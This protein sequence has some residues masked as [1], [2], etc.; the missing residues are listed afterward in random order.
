[1]K[2]KVMG[3]LIAVLFLSGCG[4][5]AAV[6]ENEVPVNKEE[7]MTIWAW[8]E[9]FNIPAANMAIERYRQTHEDARIEVVSM[10]QEE[11]V[12]RLKSAIVSGADNLLPD[13]VLIEDYRIQHF[14]KNYEEEFADLSE[15]VHQDDF[16]SYKMGVNQINGKIY[17][18]PFDSG[19]VGL[20]YRLDY[21]EAAGYRE[22]DMENLTWEEY[23]A[24]GKAVK[25]ATGKDM[26][27]LNPSDLPIIRMMLQ[28]AGKWYCDKNGEVF[29]ADNQA[30]EEA[31]GVYRDIVN[32][33]IARP[34]SDWSQFIGTFQ[35]GEVASV[36]SGAWISS[37]ILETE[38]QNG[39]WRV[40]RL[41]SMT[42]QAGAGNASSVGGSGWYIMKNSRHKAEAKRFLKE[43]FASDKDLINQL[44]EAINLVSTLRSA[45]DSENYQKGVD[46]YGQQK[47]FSDFIQWTY[48]I[49][50][51]NYGA[52]TYGMEGYVAEAIQA[53]LAGGNIQDTLMEYQKLYQQDV[54]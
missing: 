33:E 15:I 24:I 8:D 46:F 45:E 21:I 17:G 13:I 49:P 18:V 11:A 50:A 26:L 20:F 12:A 30:L 37:T 23:I 27:A 44:V 38:E 3:I 36:V 31:I 4:T 19:V 34:I 9:N 51:V 32:A 40:T 54:N 16:A 2:Y 28:S 35:S 41:P 29:I 43:T 10:S 5:A 14:L 42:R 25:E 48:E 52:D 39:L 1:M 47:I 53:I 22:E 6:N 7:T